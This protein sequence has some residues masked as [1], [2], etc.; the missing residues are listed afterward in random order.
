ML[1]ILALWLFFAAV[2]NFYLAYTDSQRYS[3][4]TAKERAFMA[5]VRY[6]L[7]L[8]LLAIGVQ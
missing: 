8:G 3:N 5:F 6:T 1:T 4:L 2:Y 7:M